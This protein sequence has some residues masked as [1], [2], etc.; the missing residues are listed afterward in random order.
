M[1]DPMN[2]SMTDPMNNCMTDR[3]TKSSTNPTQS[4][5]VTKGSSHIKKTVKKGDIV[6]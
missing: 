4:E 2:D 1:T 6:H 5:N 3:T